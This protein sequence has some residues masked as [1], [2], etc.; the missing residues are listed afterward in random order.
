MIRN[1]GVKDPILEN[2]LKVVR[3][4]CEICKRFSKPAPHP[5]VSIPI[6][7]EFNE[8]VAIDLKSYEGKYFL[9]MVDIF[10]KYCA[11]V[12]INDKKPGTIIDGMFQ[13]WISLFG[14]PTKCLSD[15]GGEFSNSDFLQFTEAFNIKHL[16][17]AAESPWS[18]GVCE[19][20]NSVLG[21]SVKKIIADCGCSIQTALAWAVSAR[22]ALS[23]YSGYS[24]NQLV[25]SFN[26]ALPN[27]S[28][29]KLSSMDRSF[30][31]EMVRK[32]LNAM[33]AARVGFMRMEYDR[34]LQRAMV[35]NIRETK[36]HDINLQDEVFYKRDKCNEWRGPGTVIGRDGKQVLVKHGGQIVRVHIC[37]A[38][39]SGK[40]SEYPEIEMKKCE[41]NAQNDHI[42]K[43]HASLCEHTPSNACQHDSGS[44]EEEEWHDVEEFQ[45]DNPI[46]R[47]EPEVLER[48]SVLRNAITQGRTSTTTGPKANVSFKKGQRVKGVC[49]SSGQYFTGKIVGRAGK[50]TSKTYQNCFNIEDDSNKEIGCYDVVRDFSEISTVEDDE[51]IAVLFNSNEV[52]EAKN[53][54]LEN[55]IENDV[56]EE[57]VDEG[58]DFM[59][60]KWVV[61][62]KIKENHEVTKARLVV[63]GFEEVEQNYRKDSPTCSKQSMR[64]LLALSSAQGWSCNSLD[65]RSA[66]L[67]GDRIEREV[68]LKPPSE[69]YNGQL[70]RL[71]KSV[72]G[73]CDAARCWYLRLKRELIN[74]GAEMSLYDNGVFSY[75]HKNEIIGVICL[76]VDDFLWSGTQVFEELII[77]KICELFSIGSSETQTFK[78]LGLQIDSDG[79][80]ICTVDQRAY[81]A[82]LKKI[83]ISRNRLN[84]SKS[85]LSEK[86]RSEYRSLIGQLN[87]MATQ[88]RPDIAFD[89]CSLSASSKN[90]TISDVLKANKLVERV[91]GNTVKLSFLCKSKLS[92]CEL[93]CFSDASFA[94]LSGEGSQGG[95]VVCLKDSIGNLLP[96]H[97]HS[98]RIKRVVKSTLAAETL[99]AVD[100]AEEAI[101]ISQLI[102]DLLKIP[103]LKI[104]CKIDNKSLVEAIQ[105]SKQVDGKRLRIEIAILKEMLQNEVISKISWV[106]TNNQLAN[107]LTKGGANSQHLLEAISC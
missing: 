5:I 72:Y 25:F 99:A 95:S 41:N 6:A 86:E 46:E 107:C 17:T 96:L 78:Y 100:G 82:S 73:L 106:S 62:S 3:N 33:H 42:E 80:T 85:F 51:E 44:A 37:R 13:R 74:L 88:T 11:A 84:N 1:S 43:D 79:K 67:Q 71:K 18:N 36:D 53:K 14:S 35:S 50:A 9:V 15:N 97:W 54:E 104:T 89:V 28:Q 40:T 90:A 77:E 102:S 20:L 32:N 94:N 65:I 59:T 48:Q 83:P 34:K 26:P 63:R 70:W 22:N 23:T 39:K 24:P 30:S 49:A 31:S 92:D 45:E 27:T 68:Y 16:T 38:A 91:Q 55:W 58:Q 66:Y 10:T 103:R 98:K 8:C 64:T 101:Y 4:S 75:M 81:G 47:D 57:V 76:Y 105:S 19:R 7:T 56:F 69:F 52:F 61:T 29:N 21:S 93:I 12:L 60:V 87:W 2:C